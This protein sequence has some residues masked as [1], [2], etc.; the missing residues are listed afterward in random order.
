MSKKNKSGAEFISDNMAITESGVIIAM[1]G[2]FEPT[3]GTIKPKSP[4][5]KN[6]SG[7]TLVAPWGEDNNFP[8][9]VIERALKDLGLL[10][11]LDKK[12]R[13]LQGREVI[14]VQLVWNEDK[15]DYDT[16]RINDL[17]INGFLAG[18]KFKRYWREACVDFTW[19]HNVFPDIIKD[20]SE[21]KIAYLGTHDA[22]WCR[23]GLQND[24]G[25]IDTCYVSAQWPDAKA[26]DDTKVMTYPVL[27][28]YS[29]SMVEDFRESKDKRAVYPANYP[30][31]GQAYYPLAPWTQYLFSEWCDIK[32]KIPKWK[33]TLM[34]KVLSAKYILTIPVTY[35]A[36]RFDDWAKLTPAEKKAKKKEV[37]KE[38]N[39]K[40][41]GIDNA[42]A[43]ILSEIGFDDLGKEIP[44]FKIIP[45][46][47]ILKDGQYLEDSQEAVQYMLQCLDLDPT[48][49]GNGPGRGKDA[50]S[51]SDKRVAFNILVALLQPYRDVILEP[52]YFVAEYNGWDK[53]HPGL[54]FVV[55]EVELETLDKSHKTAVVPNPVNSNE[56]VA[57]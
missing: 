30:S 41:T 4:K 56:N 6:T 20:K 52:L 39:D 3:P 53:T 55:L 57:A 16:Q 29:H 47:N 10:S 54:R 51:G 36:Q 24:D 1:A 33:K 43:T 37:V 40:L 26:D 13:L 49:V 9:D 27:D 23:W 32:A 45:I 50:G 17:A 25:D 7:S 28:P 19:F 18:R 48:I 42:G 35:W 46:D 11:L 21:D 2:E 5:E 44:A 14:A 8:Q 34:E 22:A 31:P 12:G 15:K 38:I